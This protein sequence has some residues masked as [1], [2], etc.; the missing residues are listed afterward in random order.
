MSAFFVKFAMEIDELVSDFGGYGMVSHM[1]SSRDKLSKAPARASEA[2][3]TE[4]R[5]LALLHAG[6][7]WRAEPSG[8][9]DGVS[10]C[11]A[12]QGD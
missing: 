2:E 9:G 5:V 11:E 1:M 7:V 3:G 8:Q 10:C 6:G 12:R 4:E